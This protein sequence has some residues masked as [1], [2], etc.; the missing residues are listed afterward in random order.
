MT[1]TTSAEIDVEADV[2]RDGTRMTL[3]EFL[4]LPDAPRAELED[5]VFEVVPPA[6]GPHGSVNTRL[7]SRL[8]PYVL[9]RDL[10]ETYDSSTAFVLRVGPPP[11]VRSPDVSFVRRGKDDPAT[12]PGSVPLAPDLAV[13]TL[14]PSDRAGKV[15]R[16]IKEYFEHGT[17]LVWLIDPQHRTAAVYTR[18][19]S[20]RWLRESDSLDGGNVIPGFSVPLAFLFAGLAPRR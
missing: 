8:A 7:L 19:G 2:P 1:T 13:E 10:G 11:L 15:P 18:D 17:S 20:V 6:G 4:A 14:S 12:A 3:D 5:G 9:D 16:K